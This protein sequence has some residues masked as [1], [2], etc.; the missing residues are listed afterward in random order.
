M[1]QSEEKQILQV[2]STHK[3]YL[4]ANI[5]TKSLQFLDTFL[6]SSTVMLNG[7]VV[8]NFFNDFRSPSLIEH[9]TFLPEYLID[10]EEPILSL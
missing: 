3:F 8:S 7:S 1:C 9:S 4:I 10:Y 6:H 2:N 5:N